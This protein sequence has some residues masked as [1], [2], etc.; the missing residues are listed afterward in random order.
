MIRDIHKPDKANC[1][2]T[3]S[4]RYVDPLNLDPTQI[5]I[6]DIA[7]ALSNQCRFGGH[8]QTFYSVAEHSVMVSVHPSIPD[9]LRLAALLHDASEA[10]L[11]DIPTPIKHRLPQYMA[12]E[13]HAM[14][15]IMNAFGFDWAKVA[16]LIKVADHD[17]L[18][19]EWD[20]YVTRS[21][22]ALSPQ[23]AKQAFLARWKELDDSLEA[24]NRR[25][26]SQSGRQMP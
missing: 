21:F 9:E 6:I 16:G 5:D 2:R 12:A 22:P 18:A 17:C 11:V 23:K 25:F 19:I 20:S 7:H 4:G 26:E 8:T 15:A 13:E 10:Y 1:I 3:Y 24:R 14:R